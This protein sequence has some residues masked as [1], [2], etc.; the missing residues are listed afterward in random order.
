ML[1]HAQAILDEQG[2]GAVSISEIARRM[3][4]KPPSLYKHVASLHAVYDGL[5]ARGQHRLWAAITAAIE[6]REP[7]LD[8]LM[9]G[10]RAFLQW[11]TQEMGLASLMFWRP[12]PG[13]QPSTESMSIAQNLITATRQELA[14]AVA[15][16]ELHRDAD[17]DEALRLLTIL[18]SGIYSQQASNQPGVAFDDG[19]F[20]SLTDQVLQLFLDRYRPA[21]TSSDP[22][23]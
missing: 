14:N 9:T 12:I 6:D 2:A 21:T 7:G 16:G 13:F 18:G 4:I 11:S 8:T 22:Q 3:E 17:S 5:F 19:L 20:T 10:Q 23:K 15:R 1:D